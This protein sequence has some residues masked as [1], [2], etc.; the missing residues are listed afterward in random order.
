MSDDC[1]VRISHLRKDFGLVTA[2][3]DVSLEVRRGQVVGLIGRNGSG[4]STLLRHIPGRLRPSG[5]SCETFGRPAMELDEADLTRIGYVDQEGGLVP[6]LDVDQ[7]VAYVRA[8]YPTWNDRLA[9]DYLKRFKIRRGARVGTLSPGVRQQ[10]ALILAIGF[11]PELIVLDEPASA[12]DPL[13]RAE[14]RALVMELVQDQRRSILLS[15]HLLSDVES[16]VDRVVMMHE[17]HI[18]RDAP[19]DEL[20]DGYA[21][22]RLTAIGIALPRE[23]PI[24]GVV[25]S[26]RDAKTAV[27]MVRGAAPGALEAAGDRLGC[28]VE[29][30]PVPLDD[31]YRLEIVGRDR[32]EVAR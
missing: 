5:G 32:A 29:V 30:A 16:L 4:K 28:R 14:F 9:R 31:I 21:E 22:V 7:H 18:V 23:L 12:M 26:R 25:E 15:S 8:Y 6:F 13:A 3:D 20:R 11:E 2:L 24:P 10:L 19:L 17:G 27:L 1:V